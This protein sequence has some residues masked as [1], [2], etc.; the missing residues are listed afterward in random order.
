MPPSDAMPRFISPFWESCP[1]CRGTGIRAG[2]KLVACAQCRGSGQVNDRRGLPHQCTACKGAGKTATAQCPRCK[3]KGTAWSERP[4][5]IKIPG[6]VETG[7]RLQVRGMGLR[8]RDGGAAGDFMVVVHVEKHPFFERDGLDIIC[9]VPIPFY[10]AMLGGY[11]TVPALE[12]V[13]KIKIARGLQ[14]GAE[15]RL[16]GTGA[17]SEKSGKQ[18]DMVYRFHI[19]MPK[20]ISRMEKKILQQLAEQPVHDGY[21]LMAAFRKKLQKLS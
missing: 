16:K 3:G 15:V 14:S 1:Q 9:S 10:Q 6:G 18:G 17:V 2:S 12:G 7:A 11:V 8:G 20:K 5:H 19:E 4:V 21:R 13:K